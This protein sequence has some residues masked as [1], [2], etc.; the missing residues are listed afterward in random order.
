VEPVAEFAVLTIATVIAAAAAFAVTWAF[1]LGAFHLMQ[2]AAA[3]SRR[4]QA[5]STAHY[6]RS[7]L[8]RGTRAVAQQLAARR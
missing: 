3:R 7:E 6:S 5:A 4:S 2:P 8:V 1:L